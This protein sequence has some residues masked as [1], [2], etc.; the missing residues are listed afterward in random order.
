MNIIVGKTSGF[1]YGVKRAVMGAF[2]ETGD[3]LYAL[4]ELV[5]NETVVNELKDKGIIV[6]EDINEAPMGCNLDRK[7]VV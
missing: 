6:I 4:G 7:S 3:N 5:H 1:C 2:N